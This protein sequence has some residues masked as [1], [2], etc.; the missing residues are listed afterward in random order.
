MPR[1][2][3]LSPT[4]ISLYLECALKYR[5]IYIDKIGRFYTRARPYYSLGSTLHQ[6]LEGFH[7]EGGHASAEEMAMDFEKRWISAGYETIEQEAEYRLAGSEMVALYHRAAAVRSAEGISTLLTE[8]TLRMDFGEFTLMGRI[9]RV[10][11]WPDGSLEIVDYKSGR[12]ETS[13][14]EIAGDLA[15]SIYQLLVRHQY[16]G[17]K[18]KATIYCLRTGS[19]ASSELNGAQVDEFIHDLRNLGQD[20]L[21]RDYESLSPERIPACETCDFLRLCKKG[22]REDE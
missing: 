16:P 22:F 7:A 20:I 6:V 5:Y 14:E 9:D 8:R 10:D 21:Q 19:Q 11:R 13:T 2:P 3:T 17:S 18:V 4:R 12:M 15:M 1:K